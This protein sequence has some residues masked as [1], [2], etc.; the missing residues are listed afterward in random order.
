[1][2]HEDGRVT[3]VPFIKMMTSLKDCLEKSLEKILK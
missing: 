2:K 3:T 1:M